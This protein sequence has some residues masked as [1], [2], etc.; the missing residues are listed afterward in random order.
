MSL[1]VLSYIFP[2]W[3]NIAKL[4]LLGLMA[5]TVLDALILFFTKRGLKGTRILPEKLSNGDQNP[6]TLTLENFYTFPVNVQII[7]EIPEQFQ[8]RDFKID[9]C[10]RIAIPITPYR[11]WR[12]SFW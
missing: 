2:R 9:R 11:T 8:V 10:N 3:F 1:L 12:I 5:L 4:V 6:I 7:D